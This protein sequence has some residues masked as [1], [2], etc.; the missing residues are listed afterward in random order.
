MLMARMV[1]T[2][3]QVHLQFGATAPTVWFPLPVVAVIP[4]D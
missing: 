1:A 2:V 3:K 4:K